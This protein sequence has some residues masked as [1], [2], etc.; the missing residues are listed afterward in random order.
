M[1]PVSRNEMMYLRDTLKEIQENGDSLELPHAIEM[2]MGF[3]EEHTVRE[4]GALEAMLT[5]NEKLLGA[6]NEEA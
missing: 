1:I 5:D 6:L 4:T 2:V 3:L